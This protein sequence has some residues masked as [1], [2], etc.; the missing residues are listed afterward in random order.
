MKVYMLLL[1]AVTLSTRSAGQIDPHTMACGGHNILDVGV[2]IKGFPPCSHC[3][4][5]LDSLKTGFSVVL[6]D[7]T[8]KL[9]GFRIGY[10]NHNGL[11]S[12]TEIFGNKVTN[13]NVSFLSKLKVGDFLSIECI[14]IEKDKEISL[15]TDMRIVID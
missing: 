8:F 1:L 7:T 4:I 9:L 14:N 12:E 13:K 2:G 15:S 11:Q 5:K 6:V 10:Y 3:V